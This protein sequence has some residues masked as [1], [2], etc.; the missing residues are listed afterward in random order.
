MYKYLEK[1]TKQPDL[2]PILLGEGQVAEFPP[3]LRICLFSS[4]LVHEFVDRL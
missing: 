4:K 1:V 2:V 3:F